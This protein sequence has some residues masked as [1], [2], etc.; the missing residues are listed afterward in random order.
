MKRLLL[1]LLCIPALLLTF[2]NDKVNSKEE[3]ESPASSAP[4]QLEKVTYQPSEEIICNPERGFFTHQEYATDNNHSITPA[5]LK[6]CREKG[7][8]LIFTAY[9]MRD[10]KD[11]LI[12]EEYLQRIR[13]N[14]LALR[15]GGAKSVLRFAYT[16]SENEKPWDAPRELTE[17]HIQQLKPIL[18]EFSDVICVLEAGFVGVWG[19]WYYTDHYNY[20]PKK[21][22]NAVTDFA[23][24]HWSYINID[25]HPAVIN[26]WEDEQCMKEIQKRLGYRFTLSEGY[27]T[28]KGEIGCPYEVVLKLQNTG[29]AAPFNPRDVEIVFVHKKK[30]EN[31]YKIKLK[32]DP[33]F[34]FPNEQ[35]T[36]QAR[37]GLPESMPSGEYD[38]Y[39]NLPDPRPTISARWEYS[40][41]LANKD[42]WNKQYGYNKIHSTMLV[43][44]SNKASFVGES[45]ENFQVK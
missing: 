1:S 4:D 25:Y 21:G 30:K 17:Q 29:W 26:Q 15:K 28:P 13:N 36:I 6:E 39:L 33:R 43:T 20:Q 41:Q 37:F 11:K 14:M 44:N 8:S 27:F 10:F 18:E 16:S 31:K 35:I 2:C 42:V 23:K 22:E 3:T 40:I 24:Y 9:Y 19:E 38:I 32:E 5:F 7:M 12:S 45:L 34:W